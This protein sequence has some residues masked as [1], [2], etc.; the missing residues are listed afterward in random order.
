MNFVSLFKAF[1][2]AMAFADAAKRFRATGAAARAATPQ[3]PAPAPAPTGTGAQLEA[4]LTSVVV[5]ALKEAFDRDHA[6]LELE[7]AQIEAERS[8]ANAAM[9][10]ELR[11]QAVDREV[12]RL[13]LL[14]LTSMTGWVVSVALLATGAAGGSTSA[15]VALVGGWMLLLGALGAAFTAQRPVSA[16]MLNEVQGSKSAVA[17]LWLMIAGLAATALSVLV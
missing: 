6:R 8:R 12:S 11:R 5:A 17:A 14:A 4:R 15:R 16:A 2:A 9:E 3:S 1:D 13:R 10:M 7:R